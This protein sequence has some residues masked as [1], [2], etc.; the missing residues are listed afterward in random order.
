L[1]YRRIVSTDVNGFICKVTVP[2]PSTAHHDM[3]A[4]S[5]ARSPIVRSCPVTG[6]EADN[7]PGLNTEVMVPVIDA[8]LEEACQ[9]TGFGVNTRKVR[10]FV[11]MAKMAGEGEVRFVIAPVKLLRH[12]VLDVKC[13]DT[14]SC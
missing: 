6:H 9:P 2:V 10:P 7:V 1:Q 14:K 3:P 8:G 11:T 12:N 5:G 13:D 4:T